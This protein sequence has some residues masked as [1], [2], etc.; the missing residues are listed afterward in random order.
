VDKHYVRQYI[1]IPN[2]E[3]KEESGCFDR[4]IHSFRT[5]LRGGGGSVTLE[6]M[7]QAGAYP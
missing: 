4:K 1:K 5:K 3:D 2:K 6:K 7:S